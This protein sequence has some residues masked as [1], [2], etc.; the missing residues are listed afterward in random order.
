M[1]LCLPIRVRGQ[2]DDNLGC[3]END[4][5]CL[6][7]AISESLAFGGKLVGATQ[8]AFQPW[9]NYNSE[10]FNVDWRLDQN[11]LGVFRA[12]Y[13]RLVKHIE[14][15]L[16]SR[17]GIV[18]SASSGPG[19]GTWAHVLVGMMASRSSAS[20]AIGHAYESD[21]NGSA[22]NRM[23]QD[24]EARGYSHATAVVEAN[25]QWT[26]HVEPSHVNWT[27]IL[28]GG[29]GGLATTY[30]DVKRLLKVLSSERYLRFQVLYRLSIIREQIAR[31]R[32]AR[33]GWNNGRYAERA[34]ERDRNPECW[35]EYYP[36]VLG[37]PVYRPPIWRC[38]P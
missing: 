14:N 9:L 23:V 8:Q 5:L 13:P 10:L 21:V 6:L 1:A 37:P 32:D 35:W 38:V 19:S 28:A 29:R 22:I 12:L 3:P 20:I 7:D 24:L 25:Y 27:N 36:P 16:A 15:D 31:D 18:L 26:T 4:E 34:A 17:Y 30:A 11:G 2:D 33:R